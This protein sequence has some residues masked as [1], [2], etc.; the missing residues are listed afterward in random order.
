MEDFGFNNMSNEEFRKEFLRFLS[1]Y[2]GGLDDFMKKT[3]GK[4]EEPFN[5]SIFF[6]FEPIDSDIINNFLKNKLDNISYD[7]GL[8]KNGEWEKNYW[9]S[10]DGLTSFSSFTRNSYFNPFEGKVKFKEES[11]NLETIKILEKKLDGFVNE[12]R[13]EEAARI[14]DLIKSLKEDIKK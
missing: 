7:K 1:M 6:N 5:K 11:E 14:R 8:D 10:P 12:E 4:P 13:Y 2:R 3:Y 9:R